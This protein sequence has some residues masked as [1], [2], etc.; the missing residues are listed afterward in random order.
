MKTLI[1]GTCYIA[2]GTEGAQNYSGRVVR[3]WLDLAAKLNPDCDILLVD[4][5]SPVDLAEILG[6]P[7]DDIDRPV[8]V[9][10]FAENIGHLNTTG[11]DGWGRAFCFSVEYAIERG[12]DNLAYID[13]DIIFT[14]PVTPILEKMDRCGVLAASPPAQNYAF[15]ENGIM[16]LDV[17]YL[18]AIDF[19]GQYDWPNRTRAQKLDEI[20]E[21]VCERILQ[22]DLFYLPIRAYRDANS[23]LTVNNV[24]HAFP[25]GMDAITHVRDIRVYEKFIAMKGIEL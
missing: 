23:I 1:V 3:L 19:V 8:T 17:P 14:L 13:A 22:H 11:K 15:M 5:F 4:S 25:Y 2:A 16:F 12:Y 7:R 18:R 9:H 20:P 10:R 21:M 6:F 24:E